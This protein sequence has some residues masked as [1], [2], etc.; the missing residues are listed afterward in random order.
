MSDY[1]STDLDV[2]AS[3]DPDLSEDLNYVKIKYDKLVKKLQD[4]SFDINKKIDLNIVQIKNKEVIR[5]QK[6]SK[7]NFTR[8]NLLYSKYHNNIEN[9]IDIN[10]P[11]NF[12]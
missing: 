9:Q 8:Y 11:E 6:G 2:L 4:A 10:P 5:C 3:I 7:N 12:K 1:D